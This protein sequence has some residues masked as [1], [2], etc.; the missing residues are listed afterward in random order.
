MQRPLSSS[1]ALI[2]SLVCYI[3]FPSA[4]AISLSI[5][6]LPPLSLSS[7]SLA[8]QVSIWEMVKGHFR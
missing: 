2:L 7:V 4:A 3:S 8:S 6:H 1:L 5:H